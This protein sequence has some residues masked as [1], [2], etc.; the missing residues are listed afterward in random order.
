MKKRVKGFS[1]G[2]L[3]PEGEVPQS[4]D[5]VDSA[6]LTQSPSKEQGV[7]PEITEGKHSFYVSLKYMFLCICVHSLVWNL[8]NS[9]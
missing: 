5:A 3:P 2:A 9:T 8:E 1:A 4:E 6:S 7:E